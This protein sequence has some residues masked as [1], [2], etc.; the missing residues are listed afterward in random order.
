MQPDKAP[1]QIDIDEILRSKAG[2]KAKRIPRFIVAWLKRRLHQD[3]VNDFLRIIGD[4]EG[5]PWLKG[6]LDF[7]DTKLE[8]KGLENL[9]SDADGRRFTFVSNHP[10]GGQDGVA[11]GYVLGTHYDGRIK[12][13]VNDLL[14]FLPGLAPL[15]IPINKTGKQSR[16]FPAMVEAGF[17]GDDHILMFPAGLCSRRR[18]GVIR[19]LPWN[20]TFITKSIETHRDVVPIYFDGRNSDKFYRL[21]N[22]GKRLGLKF[23]IAMLYLSDEMFK[24]RGDTF[25][26]YIGRPIPWQTFDASRRPSEWATWVQQAVYDIPHTR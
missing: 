17:S 4:K 2:P 11:L 6:C 16:Q 5:V 24:H 19:D 1:F 15:C 25:H 10:L 21:A 14:M 22:I 12:Y 18:H 20:K 26:V 7:L 8:V 9:P 13:L 23:N 3:Q